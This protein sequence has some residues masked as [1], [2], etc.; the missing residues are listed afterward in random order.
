MKPFALFAIAVHVMLDVATGTP[1]STEAGVVARG[2]SSP[3]GIQMWSQPDFQG[4]YK[5]FTA[6]NIRFNQC[7]KSR[8]Q[9]IYRVPF[10][11]STELTYVI[12]DVTSFFPPA[13]KSVLS[14]RSDYNNFCTL[15]P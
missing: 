5:H 15:Y 11:T 6:P 12:D 4:T 8:R 10:T 9:E 3:P 14:V 7:C 13:T 2:S 1:L